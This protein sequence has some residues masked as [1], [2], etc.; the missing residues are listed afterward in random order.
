[1][2]VGR[3]RREISQAEFMAWATYY[4]RKNQD[5]QLGRGEP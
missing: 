2:T 4:A 3:L 5:R 1:M